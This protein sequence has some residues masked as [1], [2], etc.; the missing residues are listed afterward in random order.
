MAAVHYCLS[1]SS[2][3]KILYTI[4]ASSG[5]KTIRE[6]QTFTICLPTC[7]TSEK[8]TSHLESVSSAPD[9]RFATELVETKLA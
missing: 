7:G 1:P 4:T 6:T 9:G 3:C 5:I 8:P 2:A